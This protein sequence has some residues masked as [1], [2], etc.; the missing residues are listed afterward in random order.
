MSCPSCRTFNLVYIPDI[1]R[2]PNHN[3]GRM[4]NVRRLN[5]VFHDLFFILI[6]FIKERKDALALIGVDLELLVEDY[7]FELLLLHVGACIIRT[8]SL[9]LVWSGNR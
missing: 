8:L 5:H 2:N 3:I 9:F 4:P 6:L 7:L 1:P